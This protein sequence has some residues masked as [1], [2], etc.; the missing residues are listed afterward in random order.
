MKKLALAIICAAAFGCAST[1]KEE[2][3][4]PAPLATEPEAKASDASEVLAR[5]DPS[6]PKCPKKAKLVKGKCV[7]PVEETE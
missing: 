2:P 1:P 7:L 3:S 6:A 4:H 5:K